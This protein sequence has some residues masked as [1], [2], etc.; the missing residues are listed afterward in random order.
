MRWDVWKILVARSFLREALRMIAIPLGILALIAFAALVVSPLTGLTSLANIFQAPQVEAQEA[1]DNSAPGTLSG[2]S[3]PEPG[4]L[5]D[6]VKDRSAALRL[7]KALFWETQVSGDGQVACASCHFSAGVDARVINTVHPGPNGEFEI[8]SG[9][10][11]E[12]TADVFPFGG[13]PAIDDIVGSQGVVSRDFL[14]L[15][16]A[17]SADSCADTPDAIFH[18]ARQVTGRNTPNV[19]MAIF[20]RNNFWDGRAV[21]EFNGV[22]GAGGDDASAR[23]LVDDGSGLE[24]LKVIIQPASQASQEVGPPNN[25]V[26]MSCAG[27]TFPQVGRKLLSLTPL[28]QQ[29]V[30]S[31]DS[32]LG[33][34]SNDPASGL[35]T[36]YHDMI[37]AAFQDR[38]WS[39][40]QTTDDGFTLMEAN[41]SLFW[42]L[43]LQMYG[44]ALIPDDTPFDRFAAGDTSALT[45]QSQ[46]G[47]DLF[48][49]DGRCGSCHGGS[50]FT[51]ASIE[52]GGNGRAFA[53]TGVRPLGEDLG[54]EKGKFKTPTL[55]N[56][57]LTGP[58]FH[59]GGY[60]SLRD[61]VDFYDRGGDHPNDETDSQIRPLGLTED[62]KNALVAFML[63][64]TDERVRCERAPFDHPSINVPNGPNVSPVGASGLP[65]A[66]CVGP[67]LDAD[68]FESSS[69]GVL[70]GSGPVGLGAPEPAPQSD[71]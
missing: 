15:V 26:E 9:P 12:L 65:D 6:F 57:E 8:V 25:S 7:G 14:S 70:T 61:V 19:I 53:N 64:L 39:S 22:N 45:A 52:N 5:D 16:G 54:L 37:A 42:G 35:N 40:T 60:L 66:E 20:N 46:E 18:P 17:S 48:F 24:E 44:A 10:D 47:L 51:N 67:F 1:S 63:G 41:F 71:R 31:D 11:Q 59:N 23:I 13:N 33:A 49:S 28:G 43:A 4:N 38:F 68:H 29:Q 56:I 62:Q 21:R 2:I 55:R 30:A 27:R 58:Y 50:E 34:L 32:V 69:A 3:V 36:A